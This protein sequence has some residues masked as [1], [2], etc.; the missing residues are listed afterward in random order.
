MSNRKPEKAESEEQ[1]QEKKEVSIKASRKA[2]KAKA[3]A[4]R[5][6]D[7]PKVDRRNKILK[8][9]SLLTILLAIVVVVI[10]N[11]FLET[12]IG[13]SLSF[14]FTS[15]QLM[16][17]GEVSGELL[18]NLEE[19][20]RIVVLA[21]EDTFG[22]AH[23]FAPALLNEYADKSGGR[24]S[25]EYINP[26]TV[27][28]IYNELDPD[29]TYNLAAGQVVVT[30]PA[31]QRVRVLTP[32]SDFYSVSYN[33][34]TGSPQ[35]TGYSAE[36]SISGAINFVTLESIPAV[37]FTTGHDEAALSSGFT[38][39]ENLLGNNGFEVGTINL[40]TSG[41]VPEDA[42]VVVMLAPS[43]DLTTN[44]ADLLLNYMRNGG[45]FLFAASA[46]STTEMPNLN[47][48]LNEYN[49]EYNLDR[50]RETDTGR[51]L[52]DNP[53]VMFVNAPANDITPQTYNDRTIISDSHH[54]GQIID[55]VEWITVSPLL[56][57]ADTGAREINGVVDDIS[58][59]GVQTVAMMVENTGFMDGTAV[60]R[61]ARMVVLGS[62]S[63]FADATFVQYSQAYNYQ[64]MFNIMNWL[65]NE[66]ANAGNLLIR[67][68][69]IV[70]YSLTAVT[71]ANPLYISAVIATVIIPLA[72][73]IAAIVVYRRRKHL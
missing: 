45:G 63:L 8:R 6:A 69:E 28:T 70:S 9:T 41:S 20:V 7:K 72:L 34:Q 61:A 24:V 15:N 42:S 3:Q 21:T 64:L 32:N 50:V 40:T 39:F 71:S 27:P 30:N 19:D 49:L 73:V 29:D 1:A 23:Y 2:E 54:I 18:D 66:D 10:L 31:N 44:E 55:T 60:T 22:S 26:V 13:D 65:S 36:S 38:I 52:P 58:S 59:E 4:A 62:S 43:S 56:Q 33:Q 47:Y 57:T 16:S 48:V 12:A 14:D 17:V 46:F 37:Y 25:V 68:A 11:I 51:H 53:S 35:Q 5:H 67:D